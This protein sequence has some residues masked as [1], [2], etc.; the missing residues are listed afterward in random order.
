MKTKILTSVHVSCN[1]FLRIKLRMKKSFQA[2]CR[3]HV[4]ASTNYE[5]IHTFKSKHL[6]I[7]LPITET[8][9]A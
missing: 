8:E 5:I 9:K 3:C 7:S 4:V 6:Q 2:I 1:F